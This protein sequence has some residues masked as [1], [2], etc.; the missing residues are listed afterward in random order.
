MKKEKSS[1]TLPKAK[2]LLE[3]T[4][5]I[6]NKKNSM[7]IGI[8]ETN[9]TAPGNFPY[10]ITPGQGEPTT[11]EKINYIKNNLAHSFSPRNLKIDADVFELNVSSFGMYKSGNRSIATPLNSNNEPYTSEN[12]HPVVIG[13]NINKIG[14]SSYWL[15]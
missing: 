10:P 11:E 14:N 13:S 2:E 9:Y 8:K 12:F 7:F 4:D 1:L 3:N 5:A 6:D 15:N